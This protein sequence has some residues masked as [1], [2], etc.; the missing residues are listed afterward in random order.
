MKNIYSISFILVLLFCCT[1]ENKSHSQSQTSY[2]IIKG[3]KV[4]ENNNT[5]DSVVYFNSYKK[6]IMKL[7]PLDFEFQERGVFGILKLMIPKNWTYNEKNS[8]DNLTI[9]VKNNI[10]KRGF[11][12]SIS[13]Q[14]FK[15]DTLSINL[16]SK[17]Y[18]GQIKRN[19]DSLNIHNV[20]KE[21]INNINNSRQINYSFKYDLKKMSGLTVFFEIENYFYVFEGICPNEQRFEIMKYI[22]IYQISFTSAKKSKMISSSE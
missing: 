17:V 2:E 1:T 21:P 6:R 8:T 20:Y 3:V 22:P 14:K 13:I 4:Y 5:I 7:D 10:N 18:M 19:Y 12:P 11:T 9:F 15:K 16:F